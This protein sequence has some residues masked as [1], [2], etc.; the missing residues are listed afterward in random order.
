MFLEGFL[1]AVVW[2]LFAFGEEVACISEMHPVEKVDLSNPVL[3]SP[4]NLTRRE[5]SI[6]KLNN[7]VVIEYMARPEQML[8]LLEH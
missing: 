8:M 6:M 7:P 4:I 3:N 5:R 2:I 1:Y